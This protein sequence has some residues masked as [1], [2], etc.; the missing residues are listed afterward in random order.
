[1]ITQRGVFQNSCYCVSMH[2]ALFQLSVVTD[3]I[4]NRNATWD[5]HCPLGGNIGWE[6]RCILARTI[7]C[8][9]KKKTSLL[10]ILL[11]I[12]WHESSSMEHPGGRSYCTY[13]IERRDRYISGDYLVQSRTSW[14]PSES[15]THYSKRKL[16][17]PIKIMSDTSYFLNPKWISMGETS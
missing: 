2:S 11:K 10:T 8:N 17:F 12:I 7:R 9:C 15:K 6:S 13:V 16:C 3:E 14:A 5:N 1:M 4:E